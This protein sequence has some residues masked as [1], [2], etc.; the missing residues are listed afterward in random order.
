MQV[1][2]KFQKTF[3]MNY[4]DDYTG[5]IQIYQLD[6]RNNRRYGCELVECFPK[7]IADQALD[8]GQA[9][10]AQE[11]DVTF[12]YRYWKN[13]TDEADL[14]KPLLDRL[15]G[16]LADQVERKLLNRIPKVLSRL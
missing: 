5:T 4:Y 6:Q 9:T 3:A 1:F 14:P 2:A 11:V 13:L 7:N 10:T 8:G 15:Q 16:V 12:S